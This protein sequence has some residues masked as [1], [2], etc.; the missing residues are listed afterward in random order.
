MGWVWA[1]NTWKGSIYVRCPD[2]AT[3]HL[4]L[5][6]WQAGLG[7]WTIIVVLVNL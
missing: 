4:D 6:I 7:Q 3:Y 5:G 2:P 1:Q